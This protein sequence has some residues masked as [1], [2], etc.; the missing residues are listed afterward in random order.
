MKIKR[1][2][3]QHYKGKKYKVIG[4][5]Y[6]SETFEKMVVYQGLYTDSKY[7]KNPIWV[8]PYKMFIK[9]VKKD[10]KM[11]YRF[12]YLDENLS[13]NSSKTKS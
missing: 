4:I 3:Y 11:I 12:R 2:I 9:K 6:H 7:G 1:G 13:M 5:G 10:G 8:R